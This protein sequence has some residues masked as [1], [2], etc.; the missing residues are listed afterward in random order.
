MSQPAG[1][2]RAART[3]SFPPG[4]GAVPGEWTG[5][6]VGRSMMRFDGGGDGSHCGVGAMSLLVGRETELRRIDALLAR[7]GTGFGAV[8]MFEG[9]AGIGKTAL[10]RE[11]AARAAGCGFFVLRA[12]GGRLEQEYPF[13]VARQL[14]APMLARGGSVELLEGAARLAAGP[15]GLVGAITE[16]AASGSDRASAAMHGLYWLTLNLAERRPLLLVIDDADL[17]D[18]MSLRFGLYLARR[19]E[20]A[21][22]LLLMAA[23]SP[24]EH[25]ESEVMAQLGL[26]PGLVRLRPQPLG[27]RQVAWL[28]DNS[29]LRGADREFVMACHRASGGNPFLLTELLSA[30]AAEGGGRSAGDA[31]RVAGLAPQSIVRWVL[32]RLVAQGEDAKH[33]AFA[34][35]VLGE[36]AALSD[37]ATLAGL[38]PGAA[39]A[40]ADALIGAS[41]LSFERP[42]RFVHP[43]VQDAVY[44]GVAPAKRA[45]AH[46]RAARLMVE[47][48]TPLARVA[49]HLV[50][51][52]PARDMWVVEVLREAARDARGSGAPGPAVSYLE[53]AVKEAPPRALRAEL[54]LELGEAQ[55]HAGLPGAVRTVREALDL[56]GEPRRRA[57]IS[58]T[59]GRALFSAGDF[60]AARDVVRVGLAELPDG[61]DDL[62]LEPWALF[63]RDG[64]GEWGLP[65]VAAARVRELL[66]DDAPGRT[67]TERLLLA[68]VAY[69]SGAAGD[70][71][72][73]EV[74]C[75][76]RRA[77]AH[78]A[79]LA[80]SGR[81]LAPFGAACE[82]LLFVGLPDVAIAE[83]D[84]ALESSQRRGSLIAYGWSS[85]IRGI[86]HYMS[87]NLIDAIADLE[88]ASSLQTDEYVLWLPA[89][90]AYLALCLID[91]NDLAHAADALVLPGEKEQ[92]RAQPSFI[93]YAYA[94]GRLTAIQGNHREGLEILGSCENQVREMRAPNPAA[95]V[96]WRAEAALLAARLGE[97]NQARELVAEDLTLA[98]SFGAPHAL[99]IALRAFGLIEGGD[100]GLDRLA[101]AV[102]VLDQSAAK[103]ELA[104]TLT[105]YGSALRRAGHRREAR[106][107]LR[108][109]LD[110]A[111][112]CGALVV[113]ARA[114]AELI[115]AGARPRRERIRGA[116]ALTASESRVA[117]M[118]ASGMTNR[119]I[120][121]ALFVT[122]R[123]VTTHLGHVYHKLQID[124]REQLAHALAAESPDRAALS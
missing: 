66:D 67:R 102:A 120:A 76:S 77:L 91:R 95:N 68:Y 3:H 65:A 64:K 63:V 21:P 16:P 46:A 70:R 8:G 116:D 83:L 73:A 34:F 56:H 58:L 43:L 15:L 90:R 122:I 18:A 48:G 11:A 61:N 109:G 5:S 41:I 117:R 33:L 107:P 72:H 24:T 103:L 55:L 98:R 32:A 29:D 50:L 124:G 22:V 37:A 71:P 52:E 105:E 2:A 89:T 1:A 92:W 31:A 100:H 26:L 4:G 10:L 114:R 25:G 49:A 86:A 94:L 74:A 40:A 113:A 93:S 19:L 121:Q 97:Q 80:D 87:G 115:T 111:T 27:E 44:E 82:T 108:R 69:A 12:G 6:L 99:A 47:G 30:M 119:E 42:Y 9:P 28:I 110:L 59:L 96:P 57:E 7:V 84:R 60:V 36:G 23:R 78:G 14:F 88:S 101:E 54:L 53:R 17:A 85:A 106:D 123:T 118:A 112:R 79:L 39:A 75:L 104:R 38:K 81:D 62:L 45:D 20:D 51:A 13:G 35:A